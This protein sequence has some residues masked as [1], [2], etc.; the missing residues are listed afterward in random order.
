MS[1]YRPDP[2]VS[3]ERPPVLWAGGPVARR[4][5]YALLSMVPSLLFVALVVGGAGSADASTMSVCLVCGIGGFLLHGVIALVLRDLCFTDG[6]R[7]LMA[8]W[9]PL[10]LPGRLLFRVWTWVVSGDDPW[11]SS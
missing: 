6:R 7:T 10:S 5:A 1:A 8:T 2:V 11:G 4:L 9:W 3:A